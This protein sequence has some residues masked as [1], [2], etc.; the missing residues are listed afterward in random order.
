MGE[1]N[2]KRELKLKYK[3][4][5][6]EMGIFIIRSSSSNMCYIETSQNLRGIINRT[7]FQL[8]FGSH[9]CLELQKDWK[10]YGETNFTIEI[11]EH[12]EYDEDES[13]IE[14]TEDLALLQ[15]IWEEKLTK[16]NKG[17]YKK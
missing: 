4:M 7:K 8:G 10:A 6:P 17:L 11:L 1:T 12:L 15:M 2:R 9:P 16:E 13:K 5:R 14:Y 3:Q